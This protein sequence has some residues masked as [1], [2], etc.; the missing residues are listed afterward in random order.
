MIYAETDPSSA[1]KLQS[2]DLEVHQESAKQY[3]PEVEVDLLIMLNPTISP[4]Y[5]AGAVKKDGYVIAND[6]HR[7][8]SGLFKD[9][10]G[11]LLVGQY[12]MPQPHPRTKK[13]LYEAVDNAE[14]AVLG[15]RDDLYVF[16]KKIEADLEIKEE[17]KYTPSPEQLKKWETSVE[18]E[19]I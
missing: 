9:K 14:T 11:Y 16:K 10:E 7:T 2:F 1:A 18:L 5:P 12:R 4:A 15:R 6:Y 8:A 3:K 19:D 17:E 13:F